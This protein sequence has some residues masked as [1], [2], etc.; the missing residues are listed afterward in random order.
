MQTQVRPQCEE[1]KQNEQSN[2]AADGKDLKNAQTAARQLSDR[3]SHD[4]ER[5]QC[6]QHPEN[7]ACEL[8]RD[9]GSSLRVGKSGADFGSG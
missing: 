7:N 4:R 2:A 1:G 5:E 6:A 3:H 8:M 9:H